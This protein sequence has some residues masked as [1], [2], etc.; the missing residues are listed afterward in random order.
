MPQ[1]NLALE[2]LARENPDRVAVIDRGRPISLSGLA[3]RVRRTAVHLRRAGLAEGAC[4]GLSV[5]DEL[6]R[7]VAHFALMRLGCTAVTLASFEPLGARSELAQR[8]R[9]TA[10]VTDVD[11]P[12]PEGLAVIRPDFEAIAADEALETPAR[13]LPLPDGALAAVVMT[14]SGTTGRAKLIR[15]TQAQLLAY[16]QPEWPVPAQSVVCMSSPAESNAWTWSSLSNLARGRILVFPE[17]ELTL[18]EVCRRHRVTKTFVWPAR[19]PEIAAQ[20]RAAGGPSPLREVCVITGG[21]PVDAEVQRE[22]LRDVTDRL[23]IHYGSTETSVISALR[24]DPDRHDPQCVGYLTPGFEVGIFDDQG[25]RLPAG[26]VGFI[27]VRTLWSGAEYWQDAEATA[28]A[29]V[30]GWWQPGDLGS[31]GADGMLRFYGRG[32]D[33]MVMNAINIFPAEIESAAARFPG[34]AECAAFPVP[35]PHHGQL[36]V[37]AVVPGPGYDAA[38]LLA[39]CRALLG[40]RAPRKL[41]AVDRLPRNA[42]G[43]VL[44]RE[45]ALSFRVGA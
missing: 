40:I 44:R 12:H 16:D 18:G 9:A 15:R 25:R 23:M 1:L 5:R 3:A 20:C 32:D 39:H 19:L 42:A 17:P 31:L 8:C 28:R 10:V 2:A 27:R 26:E 22:V 45:L 33:M 36:P 43:K 6:P 35:S 41:I 29:F 38:S 11:G 37:L 14:T 4:A 21:A 34:V 13:A 30:D 7:L 24:A